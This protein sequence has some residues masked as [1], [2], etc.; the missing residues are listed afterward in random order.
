MLIEN[1]YVVDF[2]GSLSAG[3]GLAPQID[4]DHE[5][6]GGWSDDQLAAGVYRFLKA[7]PADMILLH[8]GTNDLE[9]GVAGVETILDEI[10]RFERN[11]DSIITVFL[12]KIIN[13]A[14]HSQTTSDFNVNLE[15]VALER[16]AAGDSLVLVDQE[17][18]LT[19]PDDLYDALHP[20]KIG[21]EK[22]ARVWYEAVAPRILKCK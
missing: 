19:Y 3:S 5:G 7:N 10:E 16:I 14:T 15:K 1:G 8:V 6:H 4:P 17:S 18:A 22:M 20:R 12:A 11:T 21:Y 13:R 2:V 9:A